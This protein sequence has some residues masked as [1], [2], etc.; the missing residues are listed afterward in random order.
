[1]YIGKAKRLVDRVLD[2]VNRETNLAD[3]LETMGLKIQECLLAYMPISNPNEEETD[4][5]PLEQLV[6]DIITKL[7]T[8]GFVL[9][10]G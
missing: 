8:P 9:R 7:S 6:E 5:V 4:L 3:R 10:T 2:H 1:M